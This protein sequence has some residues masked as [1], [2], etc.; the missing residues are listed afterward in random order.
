MLSYK[1][2]GDKTTKKNWASFMRPA[3]IGDEDFHFIAPCTSRRRLCQAAI[4]FSMESTRKSS[5]LKGGWGETRADLKQPVL[6]STKLEWLEKL[7]SLSNHE[8]EKY[9]DNL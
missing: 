1:E 2:R 5:S 3:L 9:Y 8:Q 7:L 6:V 4:R